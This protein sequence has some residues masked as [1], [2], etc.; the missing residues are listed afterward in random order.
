MSKH[1][2]QVNIGRNVG[3]EPMSDFLWVE[4][5][6]EVAR[7]L[8]DLIW[9]TEP[10]REASPST[11]EIEIHEGRGNWGGRGTPDEE[12]VHY[13]ILVETGKLPVGEFAHA[14]ADFTRA[15]RDLAGEFGQ[16][17]IALITG[18]RLLKPRSN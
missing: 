17:A 14:M 3:D 15:L 10:D 11:D 1:Y 7:A 9:D 2:V 16:E 8:I 5:Q 6:N 18:S 4:F 13:S 12:S